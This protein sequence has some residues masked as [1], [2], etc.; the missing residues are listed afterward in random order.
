M[1]KNGSDSLVLKN[2]LATSAF[3]QVQFAD[4]TTWS[5]A[6]L[7][8]SAVVMGG[9]SNDY[10]VGTAGNAANDPDLCMVA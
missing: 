5:A 7:A 10:L 3:S 9:D 1:Y 4:G 2:Q 8:S 6:T